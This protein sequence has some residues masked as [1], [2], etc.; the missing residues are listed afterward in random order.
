[1]KFSNQFEKVLRAA[2]LPFIIDEVDG[3]YIVEISGI[4]FPVLFGEEVKFLVEMKSVILSR[5][6]LKDATP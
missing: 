2:N 4:E 6:D 1:M 5:I 3:C